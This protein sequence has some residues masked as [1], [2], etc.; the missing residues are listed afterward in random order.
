MLE[1]NPYS[2]T[3]KGHAILKK[4][5]SIFYAENIDLNIIETTCSGHAKEL[6]NRIELNN[7]DA[8]I[9]I[10]GDGTLLEVVNG[11]LSRNDGVKIP[12]GMIPGGSGNSYM[13]D[14]G[15]TNPIDATNAIINGNKEL[16]SSFIKSFFLVKNQ[17]FITFSN[18]ISYS[19]G[20]GV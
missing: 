4:V 3:K 15:L 9:A 8:F 1:F 12:I 2:G 17:S 11:L 13:H 16:K 5:E 10:G 20:L 6:A 19:I 14:L 18:M 7:Y